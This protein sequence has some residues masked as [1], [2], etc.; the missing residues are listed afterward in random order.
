MGRNKKSSNALKDKHKVD[1]LEFRLPTLTLTAL[2]DHVALDITSRTGRVTTMQLSKLHASKDP[3]RMLLLR[4]TGKRKPRPT[5]QEDDEDPTTTDSAFVVFKLKQLCRVRCAA[6]IA[7][8]KDK[9]DP[10][11]VATLE[12]TLT[13]TVVVHGA[14]GTLWCLPCYNRHVLDV[15]HKSEPGQW[16]WQGKV[17]RLYG[18]KGT[19]SLKEPAGPPKRKPPTEKLQQKQRTAWRQVLRKPKGQE[20]RVAVKEVG[21]PDP[22]AGRDRRALHAGA[23]SQ[24]RRREAVQARRLLPTQSA[25]GALAE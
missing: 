6:C 13:G 9:A 12:G 25:D 8:L 5:G 20:R 15:V 2:K 24:R 16:G 4:K 11:A 21:A 22:L 1:K 18:I 7:M 19:V 23:D 3:V 14:Q 17:P 10:K